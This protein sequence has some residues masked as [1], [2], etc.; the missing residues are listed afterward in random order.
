MDMGRMAVENMLLDI[1]AIIL[2]MFPIVYVCVNRRYK[3]QLNFFFLGVS[4][5]NVCMTIGDIA[6]WIFQNP[7]DLWQKII[8]SAFTAFYYVSSAFVLY[9]FA[10][11]IIAYVKPKGVEKRLSLIIVKALCTIQIIFALISPFTGAIYYV[12][13][14]GYQR[15]PLFLISQIIPLFCYLLF[16]TL[17]FAYRKKL[18]RREIIFFI[19]YIF[20]PLSA[21]TV[22]MLFRG[23]AIVNMGVSLALLFILVNIQF[24]HEI[25]MKEQEKKLAEQHVDIMLSQIQ[26][27]FLYN[28]LGTIYHL[29]ETSP[30]TARK[31]IKKFSEFLRGNM[32]SLK[33]R[34]PIAFRSELN[35][36]TNY[37]Y[38]EQQRFG[39]KL[40]IIYQ[41]NTENFMIPPLTLQPLVE[42]AVQHGVL[43]R[44]NGGTIII[45]SEETD[46]YAVVTVADNGVGIE[47]A[48]EH[49][50]LGDHAHIGISN[51]RSRLEEMVDGSLEIE[52]GDCGTTAVIRIPWTG[53]IDT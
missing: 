10:Q 9:F 4:V 53:G 25:A 7:A 38:L 52:S 35:H 20:V 30:E 31:A 21:G 11:Y 5:S 14:N 2:S 42:N 13:D 6:D 1:F 24:E 19:L 33:N 34:E 26:P 47:K 41:I 36:V 16:A 17:I 32:D 48:M 51:V 12:T 50:T 43:N 40:Q 23:I 22:Q 49:P 46:E 8:L 3:N 45:R 39:D 29:C 15:G 27:H 37:L 28:S 44:K 18:K